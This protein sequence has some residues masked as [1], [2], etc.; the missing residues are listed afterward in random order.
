[1]ASRRSHDR[2]STS[3]GAGPGGLSRR[4]FLWGT[5]AATAALLAAC[6]RSTTPS[7]GSTAG[8]SSGGTAASGG[9]LRMLLILDTAA[10][11]GYDTARSQEQT[12]AIVSDTI[13][14]TLLELDADGKLQPSVAKSWKVSDDR[15]TYTFT[16][17]DDVVFHDGSKLEAKDVAYTL[18][19]FKN[20]DLAAPR[21]RLLANI[22]TTVA[23]DPT[24]LVLTLSK[25]QTTILYT[26]AHIS[27]GIIPKG[28]ADK[29]DFG[30]K[31]IGSGPFVFTEWVRDQHIKVTAN[32]KYWR[33]GLPRLDSITFTFNT[34]DNARSAALRSGDVD[35]LYQAPTATVDILAQNNKFHTYGQ[36]NYSWHYMVVN[37]GYKPFS[38]VRVRQAV[39]AALDR[40]ALALAG[41]GKGHATALAGGFLPSSDPAAIKEP[42]WKQDYDKAKQLLK[43]AGYENGFSFELITLSGWAWQN[44]T[45]Q[46]LAEQLKPLGI[47][48]SVKIVEPSVLLAAAAK[49]D[50]QGMGWSFSPTFSPDE[51]IQQVFVTGAPA[52]YGK[53]S[54][55][56]FD[57][58][59]EDARETTDEN[60]S[61]DLT[62]DALKLVTEQGSWAFLYNFNIYDIT[63]SNVVG[64][65][66]NPRFSYRTL[67]EV[68]ITK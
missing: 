35:F 37:P 60:R 30:N 64:Y 22:K 55:A 42:V 7:E 19:R 1:M 58:T 6:G 61:A 63:N 12:V 49:G 3:R 65:V 10:N 41:L 66:A 23:E 5:G 50:F 39:Y 43:D 28:A 53:F 32:K 2:Y 8:Q 57:K 34:D 17:R 21:A 9:D 26:L 54:N 24:T 13:Y 4:T 33:P 31:P 15:L 20:P 56:D 18:D 14:D 44:R 38:D 68:S 11:T 27:T 36:N 47:Q 67:R 16:L 46:V 29:A 59:A 40:D 52:N 45:M 25:P 48:A 51:R 62:R